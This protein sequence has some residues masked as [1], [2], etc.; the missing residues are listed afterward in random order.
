MSF[1]ARAE[2]NTPTKPLAEIDYRAL[3]LMLERSSGSETQKKKHITRFDRAWKRNQLYYCKEESELQKWMRCEAR[4][5]LGDYTDWSGWQFRDKWSQKIW[6]MNPFHVPIW[7][8]D[9]VESLYVVGEQG[10][11]DEILFSQ[12][13]LDAQKK[14]GRVIIET[15]ERLQSIFERS[16]KVET[17]RAIIGA[18]GI[19][20]A[21]P[22]EASAWVS[23]GELPR[24]FRKSSESFIRRPYITPDPTRAGEMEPYRG[25]VGI[26]WRGAQGK[27]D[28]QKLKKMYPNAL[29][30]QYDQVEEDVERPHID[31]K[32]DTEGILA[33]VQVLSKIVTVSTT[34][35]HFA[36]SSG[37]ETELI[38]ADPK[39]GIRQNI[40]PWRWLDLSCKTIPRKSKWY[41]DNVKVYHNFG[42]YYAF[43]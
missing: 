17:Q 19:R 6:Y 39:T 2:A 15:Q 22:F 11:G 40:L 14:V 23:L 5:T 41:G 32:E 25:R 33:L 16:L 28:W 21:Q 18:D 30:L 9:Y 42:E 31:L 8:G 26:S 29:S 4:F 24:V 34:V 10:L 7:T 38:I 35:A 12:C 36:A 13:V 3:R 1:W 27:I 43:R 20:R 37:V